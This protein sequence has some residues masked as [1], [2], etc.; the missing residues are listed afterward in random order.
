MQSWRDL[1]LYLGDLSA[2][3]TAGRLAQA[4]VDALRFFR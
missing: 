2:V 3:L 4:V 1:P